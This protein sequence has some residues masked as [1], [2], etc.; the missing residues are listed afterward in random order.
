MLLVLLAQEDM[1]FQRQ[2]QEETFTIVV[3]TWLET[4]GTQVYFGGQ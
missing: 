3:I 1:Q 4:P 2:E